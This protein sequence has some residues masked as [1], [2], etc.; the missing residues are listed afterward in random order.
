M[1]IMNVVLCLM[2]V[3]CS[4]QAPTQWAEVA[5]IRG[6]RVAGTEPLPDEIWEHVCERMDYLG[7]GWDCKVYRPIGEYIVYCRE[8]GR[9]LNGAE[10][11]Y[12]LDFQPY[13]SAVQFRKCAGAHLIHTERGEKRGQE[14]RTASNVREW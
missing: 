2:L 3:G 6:E 12:L 10:T 8:C 4:N 1:R 13:Q 11:T 14:I 7:P 5:W 9:P